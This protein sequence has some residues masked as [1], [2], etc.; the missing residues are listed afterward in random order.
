MVDIVAPQPQQESVAVLAEVRWSGGVPCLSHLIDSTWARVRAH[1]DEAG[2]SKGALTSPHSFDFR[3]QS[4]P[5]QEGN[6][7][8]LACI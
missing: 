5:P 2:D 6:R 4:M 1:A 7:I 8:V 3:K